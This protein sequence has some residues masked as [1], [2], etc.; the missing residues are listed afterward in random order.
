M[1]IKITIICPTYNEEKYIS[2]C[3]ESLL[4]QDINK[5]DIEVLFVDGQS[6]DKTVEIIQ[7]YQQKYDWIKLLFNKERI[8]PY[9]MNYGI[10]ASQ[11]D[12]IMRIDAHSFYADNYISV[13]KNAIITYNAINVGA[14]CKTDVLNKNAKTLAIREVL[15]NPFG[16]GNSLFRIG[17]DKITE[18]DTVPFGCYRKEVFEKY[19]LYNP[20]LVRNQ[21]IELN[22]RIKRDGG[23]ILLVPNTYCTYLA[24]ETYKA[25]SKNNYQNGMWNI[26]TIYYTN[27]MDSLSFRHFIPLLFVLSLL[28]PSILSFLWTPFI[29]L[30][31]LSFSLYFL[32]VFGISVK[33]FLDKKVSVFHMIFTFYV[34]HISYGIGSLVGLKRVLFKQV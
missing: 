17:V 26:L 22:K 31:G 9:A 8:V 11:N 4:K 29:L 33:V 32:L 27:T 16:V 19:G 28:V 3:I 20:K 34:L 30:S 7:K 10:E 6:T 24:R 1:S 2:T 25:L 15:S 5:E 23:K 14:V 18:V 13:L 21:D 12:I